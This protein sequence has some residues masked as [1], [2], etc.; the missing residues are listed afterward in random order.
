MQLIYATGRRERMTFATA[1][2][3]TSLP[4]GAVVYAIC[5]GTSTVERFDEETIEKMSDVE[6]LS[7]KQIVDDARRR[8]LRPTQEAGAAPAGAFRRLLRWFSGEVMMAPRQS[9]RA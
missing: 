3:L 2:R 8:E 4:P 1:H 6:Y 5:D 7:F 9:V